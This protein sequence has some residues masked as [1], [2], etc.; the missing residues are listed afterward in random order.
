MTTSRICTVCILQAYQ[1]YEQGFHYPLHHLFKRPH[2]THEHHILE[3]KFGRKSR[4][5]SYI[6]SHLNATMPLLCYIN[7]TGHL[8]LTFGAVISEG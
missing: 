7:L 3:C 5:M 6:L 4:D 1:V 2:Y 8:K